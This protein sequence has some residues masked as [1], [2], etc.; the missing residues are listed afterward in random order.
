MLFARVG[1]TYSPVSGNEVKKDTVSH[2]VDF[3]QKLN[4]GIKMQMIVP[5]ITRYG[6]SIEEELNILLQKGFSRV[7]A[8]GYSKPIRIESILNK[9][10]EL[11]KEKIYLLIDRIVTKE[12]NEDDLHRIADSVQTAFYESEG[13]CFLELDEKEIKVFNNRF[14]ADGITFEEPSPNLFSFNNPYGACPK[15]EGFGMVLGVDKDLVIPNPSLSLYEDA[16]AC[17]KGEKMSEWKEA[18]MRVAAKYDFPIHKAIADLPE[19]HYKLLWEGNDELDGI[20]DFFTMV[21]QNLY[22]VQYRVMQARYRGR[23]TCHTCNGSRL[24]Q[25]ALYVK[26]NDTNIADFDVYANIRFI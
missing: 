4:V 18:F 9:E 17:W 23:T 19:K 13:E 25:D 20:N 10:A 7:Y 26:I 21:E 22:K 6:R 15:C 16:V 11:P 12:F 2:I 24:R 1:K 8:K 5:L 14:E 3:I